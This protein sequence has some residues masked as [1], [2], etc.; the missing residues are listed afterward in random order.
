MAKTTDQPVADTAMMQEQPADVQALM[1]QI[2]AMQAEL[3]AQLAQ[4]KA[5]KKHVAPKVSD[6]W[7]QMRTITL[8]RAPMHEQNFVLVGVNGKRYQVPRGKQVEVPLPL[9]ER[10]VI[11]QE[12][13]ERA[14][15]LR[16]RVE[17]D[18]REMSNQLMRVK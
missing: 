13:E 4:T 17:E 7:E 14:Y 18:V 1:K 5:P 11:M 9:Y 10:L 15:Q 12:Q 3:R 2:E 8:V 6:A 16:R